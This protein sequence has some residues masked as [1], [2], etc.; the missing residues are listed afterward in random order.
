MNTKIFLTT[1]TMLFSTLMVVAQPERMSNENRERIEA[2]RVAFITQK[3]ELTP[4]EAQRF[5]PIYNSYKDELTDIRKEF[6]RPDMESITEKEAIALIDKQIQQEQYKLDMKAK[7]LAELRTAVP[8]KKVLMLQ[9]VEN[10][11]N[12]ELLRK[13]Q[14]NRRQ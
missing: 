5:W 13:L 12:K 8:A 3:L 6:E 9:P 10:M 11:F 7:M 2:Q 4:D 14:E 1:I